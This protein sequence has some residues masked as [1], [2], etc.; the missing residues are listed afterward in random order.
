MY[1][2]HVSFLNLPVQSPFSLP[3]YAARW[4]V[5]R[6]AML[7]RRG[8]RSVRWS[9]LGSTGPGSA[10]TSGAAQAPNWRALRL[11]PT[12]KFR[13]VVATV[14]PICHGPATHSSPRCVLPHR[15][16]SSVPWSQ[17][18]RRLHGVACHSTPSFTLTLQPRGGQQW[19]VSPA[20]TTSLLSPSVCPPPF[21]LQSST[22]CLLCS[23]QVKCAGVRNLRQYR[24]GLGNT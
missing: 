5:E 2:S 11:S 19:A 14:S 6:S 20:Y 17:S 15:P 22:F 9:G 10:F 16:R 1:M 12:V 18:S 21:F 7:P 13:P 3:W 8:H 4:A 23:S 24:K